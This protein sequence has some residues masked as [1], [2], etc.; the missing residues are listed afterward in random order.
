LQSWAESKR[1]VENESALVGFYGETTMTDYCAR[2]RVE[3]GFKKMMRERKEK[4]T[5]ARDARR[6]TVV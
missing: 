6:N 5:A 4:K 3:F 2:P 1:Y